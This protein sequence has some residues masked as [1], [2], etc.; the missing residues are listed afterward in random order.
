M[1]SIAVKEG[2]GPL[3]SGQPTYIPEIPKAFAAV[4]STDMVI[5]VTR[6]RKGC[7]NTL[8]IQ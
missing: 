8:T 6:P 2:L 1:K 7:H 4:F 5:E 3:K